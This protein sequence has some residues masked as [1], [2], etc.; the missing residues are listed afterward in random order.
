MLMIYTVHILAPRASRMVR[1][2]LAT[3]TAASCV[4]FFLGSCVP[5]GMQVPKTTI[6]HKIRRNAFALIF[7]VA[8]LGAAVLPGIMGAVAARKVVEVL[9][10]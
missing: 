1:S 6:A 4:G 9:Q 2:A 7:V 10:L 8:Q 3:A 5:V